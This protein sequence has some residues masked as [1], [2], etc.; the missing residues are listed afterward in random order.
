MSN[1]A[2]S[3]ARGVVSV[4]RKLDVPFDQVLTGPIEHTDLIWQV[5]PIICD[6]M[7]GDLPM[8]EYYDVGLR[9]CEATFYD[10]YANVMVKMRNHINQVIDKRG[11]KDARN[12]IFCPRKERDYWLTLPEGAPAEIVSSAAVLFSLE[13]A[14]VMKM[15]GH[16]VEIE[17]SDDDYWVRTKSGHLVGVKAGLPVL[18]AEEWNID[19][20]GLIPDMLRMP[21]GEPY[22]GCD[23]DVVSKLRSFLWEHKGKV[24]SSDFTTTDY[25]LQ[26]LR[27]LGIASVNPVVVPLLKTSRATPVR[28]VRRISILQDALSL[29]DSPIIS[30]RKKLLGLRGMLVPELMTAPAYTRDFYKYSKVPPPMADAAT[31]ERVR[32]NTSLLLEREFKD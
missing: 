15:G 3:L 19:M 25:A 17:E 21:R 11:Y 12:A 31:L 20:S 6:D 16:V 24:S 32:Y 26:A 5:P 14:H 9:V 29:L 7:F 4:F 10:F 30:D 1:L 27:V 2:R 8:W 28:S 18:S 13:C 22:Q 23:Y